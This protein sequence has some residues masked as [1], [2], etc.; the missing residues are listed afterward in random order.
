M[1]DLGGAG[2]VAAS[3]TITL[4][5]TAIDLD[6]IRVLTKRTRMVGDGAGLGIGPGAAHV[7]GRDLID[8]PVVQLGFGLD[9]LALS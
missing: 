6:P 7:I 5:A 2:S 8:A 4:I 1:L 3:V 9:C